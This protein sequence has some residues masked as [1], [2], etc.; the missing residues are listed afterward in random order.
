[1]NTT[2]ECEPSVTGNLHGQLEEQKSEEDESEKVTA[3]PPVGGRRLRSSTSR[4][5]LKTIQDES[6]RSSDEFEKERPMRKSLSAGS[7][8]R[9]TSGS[10]L[11]KSGGLKKKSSASDISVSDD[12]AK[13]HDSSQISVS[14]L[15]DGLRKKRRL[16][17]F[18]DS[19]FGPPE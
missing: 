14:Y 6:I 4:R 12:S 16:Y 9:K 5:A 7:L 8:R 1:M 17:K 3:K 19:F 15:D 2:F 10:N 18:S 11:K 13:N